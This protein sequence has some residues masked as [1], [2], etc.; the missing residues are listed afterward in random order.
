M[1]GWNRTTLVSSRLG[2]PTGLA[3]DFFM[4]DRLYWCD[5]KENLIESARPDGSDRVIV[6]ATGEAWVIGDALNVAAP[7]QFELMRRSS[8][9]IVEEG[10]AQR[11]Q[12]EEVLENVECGVVCVVRVKLSTHV[13]VALM[14]KLHPIFALALWS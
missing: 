2:N 11:V 3:I 10:N 6:V 14:H 1:S 13:F 4:G 8:Q 12:C 9:H 7:V 5:S